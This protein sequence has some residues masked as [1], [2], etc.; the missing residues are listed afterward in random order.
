LK[1]FVLLLVNGEVNRKVF[2][3]SLIARFEA[4]GIR[5]A[6]NHGDRGEEGASFTGGN[7]GNGGGAR[8][9]CGWLGVIIGC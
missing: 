6:V 7:G 1:S 9:S 2:I 5:L 4:R 3:P 8:R